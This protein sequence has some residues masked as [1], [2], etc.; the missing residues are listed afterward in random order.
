[1]IFNTFGAQILAAVAVP[2]VVLWKRP[3]D[4]NGR[5]PMQLVSSEDESGGG[6]S[7]PMLRLLSDVAQASATHMLYYATINLA[8]T[9]WAG[10]LRRHLMLYRIFNPRF[11]LGAAVL[12]VVDLVVVFIALGLG[13]RWN[14]VSV[15]E[16]FGW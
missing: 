1:V 9:M 16:V 8:T 7:R 5:V 3:I 15:A 10:H 4:T 6:S 2:L 14:T 12:G 11:M 13:V